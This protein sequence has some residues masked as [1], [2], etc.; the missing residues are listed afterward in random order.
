MVVEKTIRRLLYLS[1]QGKPVAQERVVAVEMVRIEWFRK[2]LKV[3][4]GPE[5]KEA[6]CIKDNS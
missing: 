3:N 6:L 2:M 5:D 1:S 4:F